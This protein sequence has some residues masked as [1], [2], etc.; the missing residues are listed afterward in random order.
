MWHGLQSGNRGNPEKENINNRTVL[1]PI[2]QFV[3]YVRGTTYMIVRGL[4]R[5][6]VNILWS[7]LIRVSIRRKE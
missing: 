3:A 6:I 7:L 5:Q 2:Y 4:P 1:Q